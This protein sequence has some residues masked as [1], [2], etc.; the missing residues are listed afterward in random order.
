[1]TKKACGIPRINSWDGYV[2]GNNRAGSNDHLITDRYR[3]D[4]SI[5]SDTY[6]IPKFGRPP[7]VLL[8]GRPSVGEAIINKH[9]AMRNEALVADSDEFAD[10]CVRLNP[11]TLANIYSLLY[12]N[13]WAYK[14][15][16]IN[17][18]PI[19]INRLHNRNVFTKRYI[20]NPCV[21][22]FWPCHE[23]LA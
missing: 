11:A 4:C 23:A 21:T 10:E 17:R 16:I 15:L 12:L 19:E 13:K 2:F 1:V 20:N 8:S 22:D 5:C 7:K 3:K 6:T 14:R 18:A 9:R